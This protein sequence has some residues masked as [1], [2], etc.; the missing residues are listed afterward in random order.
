MKRQKFQDPI[1][2]TSISWINK[3]KQKDDVMINVNH[4]NGTMIPDLDEQPTSDSGDVTVDGIIGTEMSTTEPTYVSNDGVSIS[5]SISL[6]ILDSTT[7]SSGGDDDKPLSLSLPI[8]YDTLDKLTNISYD[9][10]DTQPNITLDIRNQQPNRT[11]DIMDQQPNMTYDIMDKQP[12][13]TYD[14][15]DQ[16]PSMTYDILDQQDKQSNMTYDILDQQP[17]M[18][19]DIIDKRPDLATD[20][21]DKTSTTDS[22]DIGEPTTGDIVEIPSTAASRRKRRRRLRI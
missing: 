3:I 21:V 15:M 18:T 11:Y 2:E 13:M 10:L 16:Q 12:N 4:A 8:S 5:T 7:S 17:N 20:I 22:G 9:T 1:T 6:D 19:Y 14:I